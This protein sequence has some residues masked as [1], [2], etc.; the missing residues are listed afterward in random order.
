MQN[1]AKA[2]AKNFEGNTPLYHAALNGHAVAVQTLRRH[3][4]NV[5]EPCT[6]AETA[7]QQAAWSGHS[8]VVQVLLE[9][10]ADPNT[11]SQCGSTALHQ[12]ASN[13]QETVVK[14]LLDSGA[15]VTSG[16]E[17][18]QTA[19]EAAKENS[20]YEL[21]RYLESRG[22]HVPDDEDKPAVD[23][24]DERRT[25]LDVDP[26]IAEIL[27]LDPKSLVMQDHGDACSSEPFKITATVGKE[28]K[29][30]FLKLGPNG[31]MMKG[32]QS[33]RPNSDISA[34]AILGEHA[35]LQALH[36]AVPLICP[37]SLGVGKLQ[38]SPNHFLVTEFVDV[39]AQTSEKG[40]GLSFA[41]KLAALHGAPVPPPDGSNQAM[42]GFPNTTYAGRTRQD[43]TFRRSW[44]KFYADNQLRT[45]SKLIEQA[46]GTDKELRM[47]IE[48][49]ATDIVPKLLGNEHL[50]GKRGIS[51][52][53]V[54][55]DL[56][57]GNKARGRVGGKG[58]VEDVAFDASC[59]YAHS[60]YEL[61]LMRMFGGFS[62]GFFSEYHRLMPK[63]SP[64]HEYEDRM[65]LYQL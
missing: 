34:N 3:R 42:F 21:A 13:G 28:G 37:L 22:G 49:I 6:D 16:T 8:S 36:A 4:A 31:E 18:G 46:H 19:Y 62:A 59:C 27:R 41:Q 39:N 57:S 7:L 32:K 5:N 65:K 17:D 29:Y 9:A 61:G 51:P 1:K 12:A 64:Q 54:H 60:E 56:W 30:Y 63:T 20:Y 45:I 11:K 47:W 44:A 40:S 50:G 38:E 2:D 26:A 33:P 58:G 52:V 43:N 25:G 48:R 23:G 24:M 53:L 35:S 14:L 55:G 15:D 10:S